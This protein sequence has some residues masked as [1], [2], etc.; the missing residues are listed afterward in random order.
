[1]TNKTLK[2]FNVKFANKAKPQPVKVKG[3]HKQQQIDTVYMKSMKVEY[4]G[5]SYRYILSLLSCPT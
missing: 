1:M 3:N 4:K 5:E 2:Y